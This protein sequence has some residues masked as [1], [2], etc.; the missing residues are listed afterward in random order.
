MEEATA[1]REIS[2]WTVWDLLNHISLEKWDKKEKTKQLQAILAL[3][4]LVQLFE[5]ANHYTQRIYSWNLLEKSFFK[6]TNK[7][8]K[9]M[10]QMQ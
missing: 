8:Y 7:S 4:K 3:L 10:Q 6:E 1:K 9:W 5:D 2:Q